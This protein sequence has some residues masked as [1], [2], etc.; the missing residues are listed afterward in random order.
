V[1]FF[2]PIFSQ[3]KLLGAVQMSG[4]EELDDRRVINSLLYK[5]H[6]KSHTSLENRTGKD[7]KCPYIRRKERD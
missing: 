7:Y 5:V 3:I 6:K 4:N 1:C 2:A